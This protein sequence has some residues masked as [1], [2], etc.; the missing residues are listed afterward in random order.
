MPKIKSISQTIIDESQQGDEVVECGRFK[1]TIKY[2]VSCP[3]TEPT[4]EVMGNIEPDA[5][6]LCNEAHLLLNNDNNEVCSCEV[7]KIYRMK[8]RL[9]QDVGTGFTSYSVRITDRGRT[10]QKQGPGVSARATIPGTTPCQGVIP[11]P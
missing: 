2:D 8:N 1:I 5:V 6:F 4:V 10:T 9:S 3:P 7:R 11:C